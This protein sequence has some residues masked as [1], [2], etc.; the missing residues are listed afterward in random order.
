MSPGGA[1]EESDGGATDGAGAG[2]VED[3][4][5]VT[6]VDPAEKQTGGTEK[7]TGGTTAPLLI[8]G[9]GLDV[10]P[11]GTFVGAETEADASVGPEDMIGGDGVTVS[12]SRTGTKLA[13]VST[14]DPSAG[15]INL[16]NFIKIC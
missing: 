1:A 2:A 9:A 5:V 16:V 6:S 11:P 10:D 13:W 7:R 4:D 12:V 15:L 8:T 3:P 14:P